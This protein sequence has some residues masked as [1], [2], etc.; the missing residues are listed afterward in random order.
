MN[1]LFNYEETAPNARIWIT[2]EDE[3]KSRDANVV[4][5]SR[6][7]VDIMLVVLS[8]PPFSKTDIIGE[9]DKCGSFLGGRHNI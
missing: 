5:E 3:S 8:L 2:Y 9:Y 7:N 6:D 4:E 1:D